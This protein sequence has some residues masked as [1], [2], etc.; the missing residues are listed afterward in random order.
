MWISG[1]LYED[2]LRHRSLRFFLDRHREVEKVQQAGV[3]VRVQRP[4]RRR[5]WPWNAPGVVFGSRMAL[6]KTTPR[7]R[8]ETLKLAGPF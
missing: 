2:R 8:V 3:G 6:V 4:E 5:G 7:K 1:S